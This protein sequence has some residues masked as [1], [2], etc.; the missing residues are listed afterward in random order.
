MPTEQSALTLLFTHY[1]TEVS[2]QF[3]RFD[4][5]LYSENADVLAM[6]AAMLQ[7]HDNIKPSFRYY[8]TDYSDCQTDSS[9]SRRDLLM[10][11]LKA[12]LFVEEITNY[13][14][15]HQDYGLCY[16][17]GMISAASAKKIFKGMNQYALWQFDQNPEHVKMLKDWGLQHEEFLLEILP[18]SLR[19]NSEFYTDSH[20]R[21]WWE[22]YQDSQEMRD[23]I[24]ESLL[25]PNYRIASS[26]PDGSFASLF[27]KNLDLLR[28]LDF[29]RA[30]KEFRDKVI[31][32]K[33]G[34]R[35]MDYLL[36]NDPDFY[37]ELLYSTFDSSKQMQSHYLYSLY[38][39][40]KDYWDTS[41]ALSAPR[42]H[43]KSTFALIE[44]LKEN[45]KSDYC[46]VYFKIS[47]AD[48]DLVMKSFQNSSA[49][50]VN[51][52]LLSLLNRHFELTSRQRVQVDAALAEQSLTVELYNTS[53]REDYCSFHLENRWLPLPEPKTQRTAPD[54]Q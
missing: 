5:V 41:E 33:A 48:F 39:R 47:D 43:A 7:N 52:E 21:A 16:E 25:Q 50:F 4:F 42:E 37:V 28:E 8:L 14:F 11:W 9:Q 53:Q 13:A 31:Y 6:G 12:G 36:I 26:A 1:E 20:Y 45:K 46:K 38:L 40:N 29:E 34:P 44:K 10:R 35:I 30:Q 2:Q 18:L 49:L 54:L 23:K 32:N 22:H 19:V 15:A 51:D 17:C 24:V 27:H 3:Y